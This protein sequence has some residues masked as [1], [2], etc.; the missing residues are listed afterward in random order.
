MNRVWQKVCLFLWLLLSAVLLLL[1]TS[2]CTGILKT[3]T[4]VITITEVKTDTIIRYE[5]D[6]ITLVREVPLYDTVTLENSTSKAK[7]YYDV[8]VN[9]IALHLTGKVFDVPVLINKK[10]TQVTD[11]MTKK[12]SLAFQIIKGIFSIVFVFVGIV[13]L[14]WSIKKFILKI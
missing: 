13:T 6:T 8:K 9:K 4:K 2:G 14:V 1:G 10:T 7:A 5:R 12:P 11:Q 3:R